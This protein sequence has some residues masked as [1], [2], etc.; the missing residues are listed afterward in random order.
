M[1]NRKALTLVHSCPGGGKTRFADE[2]SCMVPVQL[3]GMIPISVTYGQNSHSP[4][5][6]SYDAVMDSD[7][8]PPGLAL[9]L[10]FA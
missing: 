2:L 8:T 6:E 1:S 9:R 3:N 5:N 10:L 7:M 4:L